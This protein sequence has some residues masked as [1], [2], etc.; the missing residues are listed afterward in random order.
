MI[1]YFIS[2]LAVVDIP[3]IIGVCDAAVVNDAV[4]VIVVALTFLQGDDKE[5]LLVAST[6]ATTD[7]DSTNS[8]LQK[9]QNVSSEDIRLLHSAYDKSLLSITRTLQAKHRFSG[10]GFGEFR[11]VEYHHGQPEECE[12][13][14]W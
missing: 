4:V 12:H 3:A 1:W 10:V 14:L 7:V 13:M 8:P 9:L 5:P 2:V 6:T 11:T